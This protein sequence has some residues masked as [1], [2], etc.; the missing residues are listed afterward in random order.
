MTAIDALSQIA[1]LMFIGLI[2]GIVAKKLK[3]PS[4]LLLILSGAII[5]NISVDGQPIFQLSQGFLIS[6]SILALVMIVFR[7]SSNFS[8]RDLDTYSESE[9][10]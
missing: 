10:R 2:I 9:H 4:M 5:S 8:L 6:A 7:G 1:F 3:V